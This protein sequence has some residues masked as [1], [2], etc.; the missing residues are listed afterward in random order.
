MVKSLVAL[1]IYLTGDFYDLHTEVM[2][3]QSISQPLLDPACC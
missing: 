3:L 1:V 2:L